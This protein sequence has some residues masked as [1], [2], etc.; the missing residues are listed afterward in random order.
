MTTRIA[1]V[2]VPEVFNPYVI[3]RTAELSELQASGIISNN[4]ELDRLA[5]TGGRTINMPFWEDLTGVDE[6]LSDTAPLGVGRIEAN[7]DL[8]VL[9]MR[10]R[11]WG[12]S[13]LAAALAG[14]DPMGAIGELV[15][16]YWA[17]RRQATLISTLQGVFAAGNA[18]NIHDISQEANEAD[19]TISGETFL[20]AAQVM[21]DAKDRLTAVAMHS[22]TVTHLAKNDL[23]D[24]RPDSEGNYTV[25]MFLGKRVIEDDGL[26]VL[27]GAG[28]GGND[29][30]VT[31]LFGEGAIALGNGAA[32]VPTETDRDSLQGDDHLINRQHFIL[33]P[34]GVA[35]AGTFGPGGTVAGSSP[36]NG[37]L[38]DGANWTWVYENKNVRIARFVHTLA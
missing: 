27:A 4:P 12:A 24:F 22:M 3:E 35:F 19:R 1:H 38:E 8:A 11:A 14:D 20:D 28:Q 18:D 32:P 21:G 31:Y 10:G 6:V 2:I 29:A 15:A 36:T 26:P 9:L 34:R 7:R 37:E 30:Y 16:S 33:H 17:R 25:R 5:Q 13:D 23:I